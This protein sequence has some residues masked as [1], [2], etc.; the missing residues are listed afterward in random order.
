MDTEV[1]KKAEN[2]LEKAAI[3]ARQVLK[4][5]ETARNENH[6]SVIVNDIKYIREDL[7]EIKKRLESQYVTKDEFTPV[8]NIVYGLVGILGLSV[9]G[10]I[11]KLV[12]V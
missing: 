6:I 11:L 4:D 10:A 12:L 1:E 8:R 9:V 2:V 3:T 5:A 7:A